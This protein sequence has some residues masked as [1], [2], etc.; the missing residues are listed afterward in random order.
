MLFFSSCKGQEN[1]VKISENQ[2]REILKIIFQKIDSNG[3]KSMGFGLVDNEYLLEKAEIKSLIPEMDNLYDTLKN[4]I[5][6]FIEDNKVNLPYNTTFNDF[7]ASYFDNNNYNSINFY[8]NNISFVGLYVY[9]DDKIFLQKIDSFMKNVIEIKTNRHRQKL[10]FAIEKYFDTGYIDNL[11][12]NSIFWHRYSYVQGGITY[13][14]LMIVYFIPKN[15]KTR[16]VK[17]LNEPI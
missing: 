8:Y 12:E 4:D 11:E 3:Y 16:I 14:K 10:H 17:I 2:K 7:L 6:L 5:K 1:K 15:G 9:Q 13:Q